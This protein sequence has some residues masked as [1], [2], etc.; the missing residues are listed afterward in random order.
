MKY[1]AEIEHLI[2]WCNQNNLELNVSKTMETIIDFRKKTGE[3]QPL[4]INGRSGNRG[5]VS[6]SRYQS[7]G[8]SRLAGARISLR[9]EGPVAAVLP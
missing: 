9:E 2:N 1:R 3:I 7:F 8:K 5:W 6:I 4:L